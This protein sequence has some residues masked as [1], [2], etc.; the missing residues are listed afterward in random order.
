MSLKLSDHATTD[1]R[2]F[3]GQLP[4]ILLIHWENV[5]VLKNVED[6]EYRKFSTSYSLW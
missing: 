5:R 3:L 6:L 1:T 2:Y 4:G